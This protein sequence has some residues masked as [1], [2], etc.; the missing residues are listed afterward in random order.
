MSRWQA[1]LQ[2]VS[3]ILVGG[4]GL[5][6]AWMLYF[7]SPADEFSVWNHPWQG[8]IRDLHL[9][10]API[11]VLSFGM[12]WT[13]HAS[14]RLR[15]KQKNGFGTGLALGLSFLPMLF[16]AYLLQIAVDETWRTT[17]KWVHLSTSLLWLCGYLGHQFRPRRKVQSAS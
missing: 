15:T 3:N 9:I 14:Q 8:V 6:Y 17:W 7:A 11:L 12:I 10:L 16:S 1:W 13:A 2:H 5:I 4:T